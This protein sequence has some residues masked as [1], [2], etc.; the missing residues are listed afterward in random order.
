MNH[1]CAAQPLISEISCVEC[2]DFSTQSATKNN[3]THGINVKMEKKLLQKRTFLAALFICPWGFSNVQRANQWGF[4]FVTLRPL[5]RRMPRRP[6]LFGS[7]AAPVDGPWF[8]GWENVGKML[9]DLK[10]CASCGVVEMDCRVFV[11]S[12]WPFCFLWLFE[13]WDGF[14]GPVHFHERRKTVG[15]GGCILETFGLSP[16]DCFFVSWVHSQAK[17]KQHRLW[18]FLW[19]D[20]REIWF[21]M[22]QHVCFEHQCQSR[23]TCR[24]NPETKNGYAFKMGKRGR[25][26]KRQTHSWW[27]KP[28]LVEGL[29]ASNSMV[30]LAT[31]DW[32]VPGKNHQDHPCSKCILFAHAVQTHCSSH[33]DRHCPTGKV[34]QQS[35]NSIQL[36]LPGVWTHD[37][38][39]SNPSSGA[40]MPSRLKTP[41]SPTRYEYAM[42]LKS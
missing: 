33:P 32:Q 41:E 25:N 10:E 27:A 8:E 22:A 12:C 20:L 31:C 36:S 42:P 1:S 18:P 28:F 21:G 9:Q 34:S 29:G 5:W 26:R 7:F 24:Q 13:S 23:L 2:L 30:R 4:P 15:G 38:Q 40:A 37:L 19:K 39:A 6:Y 17:T 14:L 11:S 16:R 35:L 3:N